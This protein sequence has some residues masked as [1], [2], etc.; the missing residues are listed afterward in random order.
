MSEVLELKSARENAIE[1]V[2]SASICYVETLSITAIDA[3]P[4]L[5]ELVIK[6]Q[7]LSAKNP[8]EKRVKSKTFIHLEELVGMKSAIDRFLKMS[9]A[10]A[11]SPP[12]LKTVPDA[13][14]Q[15]IR[16]TKKDQIAVS[17]VTKQRQ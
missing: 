16:G 3:Q 1:C 5:V 7:L 17:K 13:Q 8:A 14:I 12:V 9:Q 2:L 4:G 6:T 10:L 11:M 15:P